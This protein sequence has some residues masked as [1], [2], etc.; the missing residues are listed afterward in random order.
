MTLMRMTALAAALTTLAMPAAADP[1]RG[2]AKLPTTLLGEAKKDAADN[3]ADFLQDVQTRG[4]EPVA[5]T[6]APAQPESPVT[7]SAFAPLTVPALY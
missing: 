4:T 1:L 6:E 5:V 2:V 3:I 7:Q